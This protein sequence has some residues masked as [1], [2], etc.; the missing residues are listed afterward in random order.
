[1]MQKN[2]DARPPVLLVGDKLQN[3]TYWWKACAGFQ[4]GNDHE[5]LPWRDRVPL[6]IPCRNAG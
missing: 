2:G 5:T 1:M 3:S 6:S 4:N